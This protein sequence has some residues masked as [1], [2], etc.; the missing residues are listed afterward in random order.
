MW[1]NGKVSNECTDPSIPYN[2]GGDI[3]S[4]FALPRKEA[5]LPVD[6]MECAQSSIS[7]RFRNVDALV[8][9]MCDLD[10]FR[11]EPFNTSWLVLTSIETKTSE[12]A[13]SR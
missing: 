13:C 5:C 6:G 9:T 8:K 12:D 11:L 7:D 1:R 4:S 10:S 2:F 3:T